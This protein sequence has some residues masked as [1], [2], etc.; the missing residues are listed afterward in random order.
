MAEATLLSFLAPSAR[1]LAPQV[2]ALP[3]FAAYHDLRWLFAFNQPWLGFTGVLVL[4]VV[5][6]SAV[7]AVLVMLAWPREPTVRGES[8]AAAFPALAAVV[9]RADRAGRAGDVTGGHADVRGGPAPV[10]LALP[11]RGA[12]PARHRDGAEPGR[13]GPGLVAAAPPGPH[14]GVGDRHLRCPVA[15]LGADDAPGHARHRGR[16]RAG[17]DRGRA[18]LVRADR[19]GGRGGDRGKASPT[20]G[21]G[22]PRCGGSGGRCGTGPTGCRW[23]RWRR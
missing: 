8:P 3:P 5:A 13:G 6:R 4:L 19:G 11:G 12:D 22:G 14:R 7:D 2:T 1:P 18:R 15:G 16:G 17:R 9:R 10:L 21:S 23:R 20:R